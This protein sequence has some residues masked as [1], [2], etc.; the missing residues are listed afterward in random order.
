MRNC[1]QIKTF[2]VKLWQIHWI[3]VRILRC[4]DKIFNNCCY[5]FIKISYILYSFFKHYMYYHHK[6]RITWKQMGAKW[7]RLKLN[8]ATGWLIL[9]VYHVN[10]FLVGIKKT[11]DMFYLL[12]Q[13]VLNS[14]QL[15]IRKQRELGDLRK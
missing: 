9:W 6:R 4:W 15:F 14:N 10:S 12:V 1:L 11:S 7:I 5:T 2:T 13:N 3:L 8:I